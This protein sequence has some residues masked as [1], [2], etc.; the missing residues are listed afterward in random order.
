M[1]KFIEKRNKRG[2][3]KIYVGSGNECYAH[4]KAMYNNSYDPTCEY[5]LQVDGIKAIMLGSEDCVEKKG[6]LKS[7]IR[8]LHDVEG[9]KVLMAKF[10]D[11]KYAD[12]FVFPARRLPR[13]IDPPNVLAPENR[14]S[15]YRPM[16]GFT[17]NIGQASLGQ[18]G[19][20]M[21]DHY[22]GGGRGG[23]HTNSRNYSSGQS[24]YNHNNRSEYKFIFYTYICISLRYLTVVMYLRSALYE[25]MIY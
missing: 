19:H 18:A 8:G 25:I 24:N 7:P 11:P 23:E 12:N 9:N 17:R 3:D 15:D 14:S 20:R 1:E 10:R 5:P 22:S 16:I 13:A 21:M 6:F 4:I 2:D